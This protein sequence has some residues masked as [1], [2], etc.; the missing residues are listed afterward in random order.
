MNYQK[1]IWNALINGPRSNYVLT[2]VMWHVAKGLSEMTGRTITNDGPRVEKVPI[3]RVTER[4]GD[5]EAKAVGIYLVIGGGLHGQAIM[6]LSMDSA[7]NLA[8]LLIGDQPGTATELGAT[9]RSALAEVG[10]IA[11]SRFLN[12]VASLDGMTNLLQPSPPT[13]M[14]NM[15]AAT[16]D[17]IVTPVAAV[18]DSLLIVETDFSDA[19]RTVQGRFWVMPD[20]ALQDLAA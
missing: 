1:E 20:P 14:V 8:D 9:E 12:G 2:K 18:R 5:P 10:N 11:V 15:L 13:V 4:A 3:G 7:L 6:I 16:L 17:V 19:R